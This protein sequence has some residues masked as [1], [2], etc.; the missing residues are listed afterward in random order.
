MARSSSTSR[1]G[2]VLLSSIAGTLAA[3][4]FAAPAQAASTGVVSVANT[5]QVR[6]VAASGKA[7]KVVITRSGRTV[8]VDDKFKIKAGKGCKP[9]KGDRTRVRCKLPKTPTRVIVDAGNK[10]DT[11]T[12]KT[13][14]ASLLDGGSGADK[15]TGGSGRDF[16]YGGTGHDR[17]Y[18]GKGHDELLGER[19]NDK[20]YGQGGNDYFEGGYGNDHLSGGSGN[21]HLDGDVNAEDTTGEVG[22]DT[23]YGGTGND[24][25]TYNGRGRVVADLSGSKRNDGAAGEKDTVGADVENL[26]GGDG[27]NVFTGNNRA[28]RLSGGDGDDVFTGRGGNDVLYGSYGSNTLTGGAGDDVIYTRA[29]GDAPDTYAGDKVDGGANTDLCYV[30]PAI[31]TVVNCERLG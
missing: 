27:V 25:V 16:L 24:T 30:S 2:I 8:T 10:N 7:N 23:L 26:D 4:A 6:Y 31:D 17:L 9:V 18:G 20:L 22:S 28:N 29:P 12:N 19:G 11:V 1:L 21:D 15:L 3:G 13:S 5:T 14:I